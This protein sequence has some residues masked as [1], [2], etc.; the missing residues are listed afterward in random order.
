VE[1]VEPPCDSQIPDTV[2]MT[3]SQASEPET[4]PGHPL[5]TPKHAVVPAMP[6]P[7]PASSKPQQP[8]LEKPVPVT[9]TV[10]ESDLGDSVSQA[11]EEG[12]QGAGKRDGY[13]KL[14]N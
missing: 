3:E 4:V 6:S 14:L 8:Q 5:V 7:K 12:A 11:P 13:W 2:P 10:A 9:P 1:P